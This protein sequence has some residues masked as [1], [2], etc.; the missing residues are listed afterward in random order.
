MTSRL[1]SRVSAPVP[2]QHHLA[3][4]MIAVRT[5]NPDAVGELR[6]IFH[7]GTRF[8]IQRRLG[9]IDVEQQVAEVLDQAFRIIRE[10][11]SVGGASVTGLVRQVIAQRFPTTQQGSVAEAIARDPA[12]ALA[13]GVID[14]LS[15]LERDALRR[16]YVLRQQP[17]SFLK[18]LKLT[19]DQFRAIRSKART[20]FNIRHSQQINIA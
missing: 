5:G 16:C 6:Q 1:K 20:E 14:W 19:P 13:K 17:E 3:E 10:D 8:L 4:L 18:A 2:D 9:S 12:V 7:P 15:A 11:P